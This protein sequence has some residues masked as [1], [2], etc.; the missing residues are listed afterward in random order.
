M[1]YYPFH[2]GDFAAHT[3]HLTWEEDIAYRRALD[4]YYLNEKALPEDVAKVARLIRMPKSV[5]VIEAVLAEF[6]VK[7]DDGW[8]NKR[9]DQEL[10]SMAAKQEQQ[11]AK[12]EHEA[13]RMKRH[14]ERRSQM[15]AALR[16]VGVVP[17]WDVPMKELQR[18]F[19]ENCNA[20]ATDLQREQAVSVNAPATAI[21]I[22]TPTP[23]P[24]P[25]LKEEDSARK[26]T[27]PAVR[28]PDVSEPVW[29][30]FQALRKT[31]RAPLT[32]TAIE[33][34]AAEAAKAGI[35]LEQA[36]AYCCAVGWQG[37]N[38][39]WYADRMAD[40]PTAKAQAAPRETFRERD[41]RRQEENW[42]QMTG[43]QHPNSRRADVVDA[44]TT[45]IATASIAKPTLALTT[46]ETTA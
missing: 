42:E 8:H 31:K 45:T 21:P 11:G 5:A 6:F 38:A 12:D 25:V 19:N 41:K 23:T 33:G 35:G 4:W 16:Q 14:R 30:D 37:F 29:H 24:I 32:T 43:R 20:P 17:A 9:A 34:I 46:L 7:A 10:A 36:L 27:P 26:R 22:P 18:L 3:A 28:P 1:N 40:Q 15:F 44:T 39:A 13:E 2:I